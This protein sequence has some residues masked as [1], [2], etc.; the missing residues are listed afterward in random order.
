VG[1]TTHSLFLS[2]WCFFLIQALFVLIPSSLMPVRNKATSSTRETDFERAH[3][4]A[5]IAVRRLT[6]TY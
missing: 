2:L 6:S 4:A 1:E 5:Q 3:R